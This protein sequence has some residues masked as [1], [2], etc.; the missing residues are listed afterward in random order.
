[1]TINL[2]KDISEKYN[3]STQKIRVI[4]ETWAKN[5]IYCPCCGNPTIDKFPNNRPVAD[6]YCPSCGEEYELKSKSGKL[7]MKICDGAYNKMIERIESINNPHF[8][9]LSYSKNSMLINDLLFVPKFYFMPSIIEKR[10]PLSQT[11][12]RA[13]WIGCNI[14][15]GDIPETGKIYLI[16]EKIPIDQEIIAGQYRKIRFFNGTNLEARSWM[17]D[18]LLCIEKI[19]KK[20]FSIADIYS[21]E[22]ELKKKYPCNNHI[23]EKLRQQLQILRD[24]G[25]LRFLGK[26]QYLVI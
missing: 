12:K 25:Y 11:A 10:K 20:Q 19:S 6:F 23:K 2:Q 22:E 16:K 13:G 1:M 18:I 14:K 3:S 24:K 26:G 17:M 15:I 9:I 4:T 8:F 21:F 5:N 7:G